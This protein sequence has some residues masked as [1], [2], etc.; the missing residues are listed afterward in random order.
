MSG[1]H[2]SVDAVGAG[3]ARSKLLSFLQEEGAGVV[4]YLG[5]GSVEWAIAWFGGEDGFISSYCNTIPTPD[6]GTHEQGLR[7]ALNRS[8]KNYAE[9]AGNKRANI[10][11]A[12]DVISLLRDRI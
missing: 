6:G 10:I 2:V 1:R 5:H 9:L 4:E 7:S 8:L 12:D 3:E 11:T